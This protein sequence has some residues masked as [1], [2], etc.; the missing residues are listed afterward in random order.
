MR[1]SHPEY[2]RVISFILNAKAMQLR[3]EGNLDEA[4]RLLDEASL[5]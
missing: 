4:F 2:A 1:N 5:V 3:Q